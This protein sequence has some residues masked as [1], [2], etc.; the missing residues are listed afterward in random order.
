MVHWTWTSSEVPGWT[1][2]QVLEVVFLD[3]LGQVVDLG[4]TRHLDRQSTRGTVR[5]TG[6]GRAEVGGVTWTE[7]VMVL[8]AKSVA[9]SLMVD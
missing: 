2:L 9:Q 3:V 8:R 6:E 1:D 7:L 4:T 5:G